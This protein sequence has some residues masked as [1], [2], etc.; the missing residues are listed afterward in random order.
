M[1][2]ELRDV[3]RRIGSTGRIRQVT[4]A[5]QKVSSAR[6][7]HD[8][9]AMENSRRY[10]ERLVQ[11]LRALCFA[12]PDVDHPFLGRR[13][14]GGGTLVLVFGSDR[15]LCG[16]HNRSLMEAF[17][18]FRGERSGTTPVQYRLASHSAPL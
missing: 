13:H 17:H 16:G 8:R 2:I 10:T 6:L 9:R 7:V 18:R 4:S 1:S 15:G 5:M 3:K 11:L 12:V 14:A